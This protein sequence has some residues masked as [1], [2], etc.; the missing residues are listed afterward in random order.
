MLKISEPIKPQSKED[1]TYSAPLDTSLTEK[2]LG[3]ITDQTTMEV[4]V[5][6]ALS[7]LKERGQEA[8]AA[9]KRATESVLSH[10][11]L[12]KKALEDEDAGSMKE[13]SKVVLDAK[14][15][16]HCIF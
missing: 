10:V 9:Q 14:K 4:M 2:E 8:I 7:V 12:L 11:K 16:C 15:V 5:E 3:N 13:L 1:T 6:E